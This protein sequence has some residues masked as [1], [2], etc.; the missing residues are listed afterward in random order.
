M[1]A[2]SVLPKSFALGEPAVPPPLPPMPHFKLHVIDGDLNQPTRI[3]AVAIFPSNIG[4]DGFVTTKVTGQFDHTAVRGW[5]MTPLPLH[6]L[7]LQV[8]TESVDPDSGLLDI[9]L[10]YP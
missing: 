3:E 4:W 8:A 9:N 5:S 1:A 2:L 7:P 10:F 6:K